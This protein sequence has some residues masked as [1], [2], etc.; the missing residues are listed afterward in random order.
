MNRCCDAVTWVLHYVF[1][2]KGIECQ[3]P[4]CRALY[5]GPRCVFLRTQTLR[6]K[7]EKTLFKKAGRGDFAD[8]QVWA[9]AP[10]LSGGSTDIADSYCRPLAA[11]IYISGIAASVCAGR[12][13]TADAMI[14]RADTGM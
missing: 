9:S 13:R 4:A 3:P 1:V 7:K 11:F 5:L 12:N 2:N 8:G 14:S 10:L 6:I